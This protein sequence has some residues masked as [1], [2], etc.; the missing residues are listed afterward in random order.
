MK[1][2][3]SEKEKEVGW[4]RSVKGRLEEKGKTKKR[5]RREGGHAER[6]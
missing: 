4:K 5:E 3:E 2:V 1:E 6:G